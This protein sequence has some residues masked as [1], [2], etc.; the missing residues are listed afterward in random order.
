MALLSAATRRAPLGWRCMAA[1]VMLA[2]S[3]AGRCAYAQLPTLAAWYGGSAAQTTTDRS[4]RGFESPGS[5][6]S[7]ERRMVH[8]HGGIGWPVYRR[9]WVGIEGRAGFHFGGLGEL[10]VGTNEIGLATQLSVTARDRAR[11]RAGGARLFYHEEDYGAAMIVRA[12][13]WTGYLGGEVDIGRRP[14]GQRGDALM[15]ALTADAFGSTGGRLLGP[16]NG[17]RSDFSFTGV[18]AGIVLRFTR[19]QRVPADS[20]A[21]DRDSTATPGAAVPPPH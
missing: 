17:R 2:S 15:V 12:R 7:F 18:R 19:A 1:G 9:V 13:A 14:Q 11:L 10:A 21:E 8:F 16:A 5:H 3:V 6:E 20:L 4:P